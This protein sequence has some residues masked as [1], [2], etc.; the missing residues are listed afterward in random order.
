MCVVPDRFQNKY[1]IAS[2][3]WQNWDYRWA[4]AYFITICTHN[5]I[6]YFGNIHSGKMQL[7][8]AGVIADILWNEIKNHTRDIKL[9]EYVVMPDHVHGILILTGDDPPAVETGH[10]LSPAPPTETG[11]ALCLH[12][13]QSRQR[14]PGK[15]SVSSIIGSYKSAATKHC[16]R[17][18]LDMKWQPRFHD[19]VIRNHMEY[20][21]IA[22]YILQN[23][24]NWKE[25]Q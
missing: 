3:R 6:P 1:R 12:P 13:G 17:L 14:N 2:A 18:G 9:G 4:G 8:R 15:N 25:N 10:A 22:N 16:N 23:P 21:Y 24:V 20:M 19:H 7:S 5:R 11:H